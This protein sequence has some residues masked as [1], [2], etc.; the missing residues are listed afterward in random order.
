[1]RE[2]PKSIRDV[3]H[4]ARA[5]WWS[6]SEKSEKCPRVMRGNMSVPSESANLT[7]LMWICSEFVDWLFQRSNVS[8][9]SLSRFHIG[10]S[11]QRR[12]QFGVAYRSST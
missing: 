1:M 4:H 8:A 6:T 7:D 3:D 5:C 9:N 12:M 10:T 11:M 2:A